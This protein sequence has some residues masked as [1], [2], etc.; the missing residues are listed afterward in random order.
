M[1]RQKQMK[2]F[3][4]VDGSY[5]LK[6]LILKN[7]SAFYSEIK[8]NVLQIW[9]ISGS[10]GIAMHSQSQRFLGGFLMFFLLLWLLY[11]SIYHSIFQIA[12][13]SFRPCSSI[14]GQF[15]ILKKQSLQCSQS[16][17]KISSYISCL[18]N[19][20]V[21]LS[22]FVTHKKDRRAKIILFQSLL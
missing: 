14:S 6:R 1:T 5:P 3:H 12:N 15:D 2:N 22:R 10:H 18:Q 20:A 13:S 8:N 9:N 11:C 17:L 7:Y 21:S 16:H 19:D 4:V